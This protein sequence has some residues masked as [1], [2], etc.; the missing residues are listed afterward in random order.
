MT[1]QI[2]VAVFGMGR[3]GVH[4]LRNFLANPDAKVVAIVDPHLE[5]LKQV[6]AQFDLTDVHL[7]TDWQR[8]MELETVQAVV[9]ATPAITHHELITYALKKSL[10]VLAE[11]PLTLNLTESTH[12]CRLAEAQNC[13]LMVDHTYLFHPAVLAGQSFL[14]TMGLGTLRYGYAA[15]T[16]LAPVRQDV[17]AL[18]DLAIHDISI[19]NYWLGQTP[20]QVQA[21]GNVWLQP[22]STPGFPHGIADTVWVKLT[23]PSDFQVTLHLSWLNPDKQRR[24]GLVGSEGALIFDELGV[25]PL[26][27]Q[28]GSLADQ[29]QFF[30]PVN[31]W[32]Q[33]LELPPSEPLQQVCAHFLNCIY[34][35]QASSISS[36]WLGANLVQIVAALSASIQQSGRPINLSPLESEKPSL[37]LSI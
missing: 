16:H 25:A 37:A 2:G 5:R 18:W 3:W 30:V 33:I 27:V 12:L 7:V 6:A 8:G 4:L 24:I 17:D 14:Q 1:H 35:N 23:Y 32:R 28:W 15:R 34:L 11:K 31:Q 22:H 20:C 10:H 13:Q 29:D 36:G 9:I 21:Q 19:F 26:T